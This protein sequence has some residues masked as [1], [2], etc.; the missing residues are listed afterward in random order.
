GTLAVVVL[1]A[2]SV[3]AGCNP[4]VGG[5]STNDFPEESAVMDFEGEVRDYSTFDLLVGVCVSL[6]TEDHTGRNEVVMAE[7]AAD[8]T[9][10]ATDVTVPLGVPLAIGVADCISSGAAPCASG[11]TRYPTL[12][13]GGS[14][15][16]GD[17]SIYVPALSMDCAF[18]ELLGEEARRVAP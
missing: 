7:A 16:S 17:R 18:A 10:R 4:N 6:Y 3:T 5:T 9:F 13:F 15:G 12:S 14:A 8:G 2:L 1:A 11:G